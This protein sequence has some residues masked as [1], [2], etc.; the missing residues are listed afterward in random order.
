M[1]VGRARRV[2]LAACCAVSCGRIGYELQPLP[3]EDGGAIDSGTGGAGP[4]GEAGADGGTAGTSDAGRDAAP[5]RDAGRDASTD[6]AVPDAGRDAGVP[7]ADSGSPSDAGAVDAGPYPACVPSGLS[8]STGFDADPTQLDGNG[9]SIPDWTVRGGGAFPAAELSGGVW[10]SATQTFLDTR[11]LDDFSRRTIVDLRFSS[12]TVAAS[13]RGAVLWLNLNENGPLYSALFVS[14][15]AQS[16]GG[17]Q[18]TLFGKPDGATETPIV[19]FSNLPTTF[20]DLHLD[21]DPTT[22]QVGVWLDQK[23]QGTYAFPTTGAPNADHFATLVSWQGLSE[24]DF[25]RIEQCR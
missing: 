1:R 17:Q 19:T 22:L 8:W 21:I 7:V 14:A 5:A 15:V 16:G 12:S 3:A 23:L 20:I 13:Q 25:V 2:L 9:D 4:G 18:L 11:P 6:G 10:T 24:F